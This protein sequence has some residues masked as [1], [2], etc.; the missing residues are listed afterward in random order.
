M[1]K[2]TTAKRAARGLTRMTTEGKRET[3]KKNQQFRQKK[4]VLFLPKLLFLFC[5]CAWHVLAQ[6]VVLTQQQIDFLPL[7]TSL[8][9]QIQTGNTEQKRDA[10]AQ[11]RNF[12]FS[13]ASIL[14]VPALK[15]SSEIVRATAAFAVIYLPSDE[16]ARNL[17]PLLKDKK[18]LVRREAA[19]AL[20]KVRN[21]IAINSLVEIFQKDKISEVRN[22][23]I[24]ALGEIGDAAT[25]SELVKILQR[26]PQAKEEFT[27]R[28]AARSIGQIAQIIQTGKTTVITP[29]NFLPDQLKV[30]EKSNYPKLIERFPVFQPTI[31]VLISV[32]Q[33]PRD[34][35]DVRREAAF[36]LGAIG[37]ASA[38][39]VL[40][41]NLTDADYYLAEIC[42]ES[43]RRIAVYAEYAKIKE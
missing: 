41:A 16:A 40:Q 3:N 27:R 4:N 15:D 13:E 11:I 25:V 42:R 29:E 24:V 14:A 38:I 2:S 6:D 36:A 30:I 12:Q 33:N 26:K 10:L 20:G 32:L 31:S 9:K 8:Q 21:L 19:Y 22:A 7:Q 5:F 34:F 28:A 23:A 37:D 17:L 43:L 35:P 39:P 18:P 1:G